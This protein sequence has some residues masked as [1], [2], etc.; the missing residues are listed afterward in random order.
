MSL[1]VPQNGQGDNEPVIE[2]FV[3]VSS[4]LFIA[5]FFPDVFESQI[6]CGEKKRQLRELK[7]LI[8]KFKL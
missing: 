2:L 4:V 5:F 6:W 7:P 8:G 3:K 1:S